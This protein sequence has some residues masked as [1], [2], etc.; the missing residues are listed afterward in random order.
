MRIDIIR[1]TKPKKMCSDILNL[2]NMN[3]MAKISR[4]AIVGAN[5][6]MDYSK[7][8][9]ET[10]MICLGPNNPYLGEKLKNH[11]QVLVLARSRKDIKDIKTAI[12]ECYGQQYPNLKILDLTERQVPPAIYGEFASKNIDYLLNRYPDKV[13]VGALLDDIYNMLRD[14]ENDAS[15]YMKS[16]YNT[17]RDEL[18]MFAQ[19]H[20]DVFG[21]LDK[22]FNI[23]DLIQTIINL[24]SNDIQKVLKDIQEND[25][26]DMSGMDIVM[27]TVHTA[28]DIRMDNVIAFIKTNKNSENQKS[29]PEDEA[30]YRVALSRA[31]KTECVIFANYGAFELPHQKYL[32]E[33]F[34]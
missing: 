16:V 19:N 10:A 15:M 20:M 17:A 30:F 9:V 3:P 24:E 2:L 11:E 22:E 14:A 6:N 8:I 1:L 27:S 12:V 28:M 26:M 18:L 7:S 21:S 23:L 25:T 29:T 33:H 31:N 13:K 32:R 5:I 34:E 4:K